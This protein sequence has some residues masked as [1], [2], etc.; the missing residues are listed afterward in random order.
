[1][2][3][4]KLVLAMSL[5]GVTSIASAGSLPIFTPSPLMKDAIILGT[6][7]SSGMQLAVVSEGGISVAC[8]DTNN[9]AYIQ[10]T[11]SITSTSLA[12]VPVVTPTTELTGFQGHVGVYGTGS[13]VALVTQDAGALI[14]VPTSAIQTIAVLN[15]SAGPF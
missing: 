4:N 1:M 7:V 11:A 13:A 6:Q 15:G 10:P 8:I 2:K 9:N 12:G 5:V 14:V 3:F